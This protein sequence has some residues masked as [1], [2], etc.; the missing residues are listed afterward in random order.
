MNEHIGRLQKIGL[1]KESTAGTP[2]SAT[3]WLP[4]TEGSFSPETTKAKDTSAYGTI[5]ELRDSQTTQQ[6]TVADVKG[7]ARDIF[8]G[9]LLMAAFGQDTPVIKMTLAG[10]AGTFVKDETV[11]Q[12]V[13]SATGTI[14]RIESATIIYVK[15]VSGTFT[16]AAN[17]IT[18]GTSSATATPTFES[19][20][21]HHLFERL[22]TN[23]HPSYTLY[24]VDD[25]GTFRAP[26]SM[27]ETLD[28]ECAVGDYLKF[29]AQFK[30]KKE[31]ST[32][33]SPAFST[34][35]NVFLA[36]HAGVYFATALSGL[37][38]ASVTPV[39]SVK[40]TISK[41]LEVYQAYGDVDVASIHNKQFKVAGEITAL[42]NAVTLKDFVLNSTKRAMRL[43]L[44]NT[45][46]T[47]GSAGNPQ[48]IIDLAQVSFENWSR[49]AGNDELVMQT[50]GFEAEF[51][52]TDSE[53]IVALLQNTQLTAY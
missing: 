28:L 3:V 6:M 44:T 47:I 45:D 34:S 40:L 53:S 9:N 1:G 11:T 41:N 24:G 48:L 33:A 42:F 29:S 51:S 39:S 46:A 18:G 37:S 10:G 30:G 38:A 5:D 14:E 31:A 20:L 15:V 16:S 50:L 19:T 8:L 12:A 32:S 35:E 23:N 13:S 49:S 52:V 25:V 4:K 21:R 43:K 2:V 7:I 36:K 17:L 26:Y 27:L 22:N